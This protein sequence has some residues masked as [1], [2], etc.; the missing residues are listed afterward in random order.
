VRS[1]RRTFT[2]AGPQ[3]LE[4]DGRDQTGDEIAN[5]VY[6]YVLR[7]HGAGSGGR[8]IRQTGQLVIMR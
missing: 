5:G 2:T 7:G 6:L 1:L 3:T 8:D 4:W